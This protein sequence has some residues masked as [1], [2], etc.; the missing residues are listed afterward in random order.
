VLYV[1]TLEWIVE[2]AC[3][4]MHLDEDF[5]STHDLTAYELGDS[6]VDDRRII[7]TFSALLQAPVAN[8]GVVYL[9]NL[10]K[11]CIG[12]AMLRLN[13]GQ[14]SLMPRVRWLLAFFRWHV[15]VAQP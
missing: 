1:Q 15:V 5:L 6:A 4:R 9:S 12:Y 3:Q 7:E 8:H 10:F 13:R 11:S 14:E 2:G